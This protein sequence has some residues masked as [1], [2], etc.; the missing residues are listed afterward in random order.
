MTTLFNYDSSSLELLGVNGAG[1]AAFRRVLLPSV[2]IFSSDK[3]D[4]SS[5]VLYLSL[6]PPE[7]F[8][9]EERLIKKELKGTLLSLPL[10]SRADLTS[11]CLTLLLHSPQLSWAFSALPYLPAARV[12]TELHLPVQKS[13]SVPVNSIRQSLVLGPKSHS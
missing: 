8:C 7:L 9:T 5:V 10:P 2:R 4:F 13:T 1:P 12:T 3:R 11:L 6:F